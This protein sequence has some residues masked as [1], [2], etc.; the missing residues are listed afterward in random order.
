MGVDGVGATGCGCVL[1]E[2]GG[3]AES[4]ATSMFSP[5]SAHGFGP[6]AGFL[7]GLSALPLWNFRAI[8]HFFVTCDPKKGLP[9]PLATEYHQ[10]M[11]LV[12]R[13]IRV[14]APRVTTLRHDFL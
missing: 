13:T 12:S 4:S 11:V 1:A 10:K 8:E 5:F 9:A 14:T 6:G 7:Y 2:T 3:M